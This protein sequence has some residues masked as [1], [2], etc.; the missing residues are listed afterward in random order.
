M[1]EERFKEIEGTKETVKKMNVDAV[2]DLLIKVQNKN[3]ELLS[4]NVDLRRVVTNNNQKLLEL[5]GRINALQA[6]GFRGL[7]GTGSTVHDK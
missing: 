3:H 7:M 5:E 2:A 1:T 4:D 6:M